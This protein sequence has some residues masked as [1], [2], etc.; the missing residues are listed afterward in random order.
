MLQLT[1]KP[2]NTKA[3][4][5]LSSVAGETLT[6]Y[7]PKILPAL[8]SSLSEKWGGPDESQV[9]RNFGGSIKKNQM[10]IYIHGWKSFLV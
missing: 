4:S 6:K 10:L 7:L 9:S 3:L 1:A 2:V 8:L 5:F